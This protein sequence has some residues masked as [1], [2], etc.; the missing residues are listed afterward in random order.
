MQSHVPHGAGSK[1]NMTIIY[2]WGV[3]PDGWTKEKRRAAAPRGSARA[4][5]QRF[6]GRVVGAADGVVAVAGAVAVDG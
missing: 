6:G 3:K 5:S 1:R 4:T 2:N